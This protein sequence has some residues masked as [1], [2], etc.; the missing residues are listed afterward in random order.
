[1]DIVIDEELIQDEAETILD[2]QLSTDELEEVRDVILENVSEMVQDSIHYVI[3]FKEMLERNRKAER[4][5]PH[6]QVSHR[7]ENA[8]EPEFKISGTFKSLDDAKQYVHH[9]FITEFDEWKV[10]Q[11]D[12]DGKES[13]VYKVNC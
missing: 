13:E 10:V 9:D 2:Q 12:K 11:V 4:S 3:G 6:Y 1:M 7:N 5:F 8:F